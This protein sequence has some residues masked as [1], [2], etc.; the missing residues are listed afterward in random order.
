MTTFEP[1]FNCNGTKKITMTIVGEGKT[2]KLEIPC[3]TCHGQGHLPLGQG[4]RIQEAEKNFWCHCED[5]PFG[6]WHE[7]GE[8][9]QCAK[10]HAHCANCG[11][12]NQVG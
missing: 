10:H 7:D 8:C 12:I 1:C 2:N 6:A 9:P 5:S 4:K 3:I 11:K